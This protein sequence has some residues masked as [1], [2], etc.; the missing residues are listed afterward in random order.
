[1]T[2]SVVPGAY[3]S[4]P[5]PGFPSRRGGG[6]FAEA[7]LDWPAALP[8]RLSLP[9]PGFPRSLQ[10]VTEWVPGVSLPD[11]TLLRSTVLNGP[12]LAMEAIR[13]ATLLALAAAV[14]GLPAATVAIGTVNIP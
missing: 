2:P 12:D 8:P 5:A 3:I 10:P 1:M 7:A 9:L 4:I 13:I 11:G 6:P 14:A